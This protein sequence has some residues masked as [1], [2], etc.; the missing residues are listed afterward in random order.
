VSDIHLDTAAAGLAISTSPADRLIVRL[1][2][3]PTSGYRW[4]VEALDPAV[5]EPAGDEFI[6]AAD[7]AFGAGGTREF[8]FGV[9]GPGSTSLRLVRRR[10]WEPS[11]AAA[12]TFEATIDS[13]A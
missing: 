8:R 12:E 7:G 2:E 13:T 11:E 4:E 1:D 10:P 6:P 5:L 3:T 9:V